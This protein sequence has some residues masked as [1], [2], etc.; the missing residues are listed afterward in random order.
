MKGGSHHYHH[1]SILVAIL[2]SASWAAPEI[3]SAQRPGKEAD[4]TSISRAITVNEVISLL[5]AGVS[6]NLIRA[7]LAKAGQPVDVTPDEMVALKQAGA[8]DELVTAMLYPASGTHA[9]GTS[10][11]PGGENDPT[12][13]HDSGVYWFDENP[14][15]SAQMVFLERAA[16]VGVESSGVFAA[17][18]TMGIAKAKLK[19]VIQ[20]SRS[21]VRLDTGSP[22]FYFYFEDHAAGLGRSAFMVPDISNPNQFTL[23]RL[24]CRKDSRETV[25]MRAGAFAASYGTDRDARVPFKSERIR[26]GVYRVTPARPLPPGE[27]CFLAGS[28]AD[29]DPYAKMGNRINIFDFGVG[30]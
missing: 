3:V 19:A 14:D 29:S 24:D 11:H 27:Y 2:V 12:A 8:S 21:A 13:P 23:V 1:L 30:Q 10:L 7:R 16:Y 25:M 26:P 17:M 28:V 6:E 22:T 9:F 15:G 4:S 18:I 5:K 20:G